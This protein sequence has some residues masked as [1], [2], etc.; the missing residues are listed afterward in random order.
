MTAG[1]SARALRALGSFERAL[2]VQDRHGP[3]HI[4]AVVQLGGAPGPD[5]LRAALKLLQQR[6]ALLAARVR[7]AKGRPYFEAIP[8]P[9]VPMSVLARQD[10]EAWRAVA[11]SELGRPIDTDR[12]PLFRCTYLFDA[13]GGR[14]E[15]VLALAHPIIDAP[16][17]MLLVDE[18]LRFAQQ[19]AEGRT[20]EAG[21]LE[22][23]AAVD[24]R[25]PPEFRGAAM[26]RR[27]AA[28]LLEQMR[29]EIRYRWR[30]RGQSVLPMRPR[31]PG[32]ILS[33]R[34]SADLT[35]RI[36]RAARLERVTLNSL[37]NAALVR[38]VNRHLYGGRAMPMRT[39][40]FATLRPYVVPPL[41][42]PTLAPNITMLRYTV[43][44]SPARDLWNL[45]RE[46]QAQIESSFRRGH[47]FVA[48]KTTERMITMANRLEAFRLANTGLNYN[49]PITVRAAYGGISVLGLHGAISTVRVGPECGAQVNLFNDEL[50]WDI[51][52][53]EADMDH[54]LAQRIADEVRSSLEAA[55][56]VTPA[57]APAAGR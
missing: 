22:L 51:T 45:A 16:G 4:V 29:D 42:E 26:T 12:G 32:H 9:P 25:F 2:L 36:A 14:A 50:S 5:V 17:C 7:Q 56:A 1:G 35:D 39:V 11:E 55:V 13:E 15:V 28:F 37:L 20:P 10:D 38:A 34:F 49:A 30:T 21:A 31:S 46:L 40:T 33:M 48:A 43:M 6:H 27:T 19:L 41:T 53:A 3:F 44:V 47:K 8:D 24:E 54:V 18:L 57:S 52:Y 23:Q